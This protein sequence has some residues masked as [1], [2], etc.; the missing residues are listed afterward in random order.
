MKDY[1]INK[2][3]EFVMNSGDSYFDFLDGNAYKE[4][5]VKFVSAKDPMFNDFKQII[6]EFHLTP[7]ELYERIYG[8]NSFK[9]GTVICIALPYSDEV[10]ESNRERDWPSEKWTLMR[11]F[12][13]YD[14]GVKLSN[15]IKELLNEKGY[16]C[17]DSVLDEI[18]K[19]VTSKNGPSSNWSQRH[20]AYAA[21]M[22][23]FSLNAGFITEKGIAVTLLSLVTDLVVETDGRIA[24][25]HNA[26]CLYFH[27]GKCKKC[28]KKCPAGAIS[29]DG[30]DKLKCFSMAYGEEA[31]K[32]AKSVGANPASG[33]GCGLCQ[34][35]VPCESQNPTKPKIK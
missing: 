29:E 10:I 20:V 3:I 28:I 19:K 11:T 23:T 21:G 13:I 8:K 1:L 2:I 24:E 9:D 17:V 18:F 26:N 6:G 30:I 4:P 12:G 33:S 22:G 31:R 27:K 14:F 25:D 16:N 32:Y 34:V 7:T 15:Y 5:L 35:G